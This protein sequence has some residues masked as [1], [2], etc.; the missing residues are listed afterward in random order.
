MRTN[1]MNEQ[2]GLVRYEAARHALAEARRVQDVKDIRD[3][4][5]AMAVYAKQAKDRDLIDH[6]T[7][8]RM[9]AEIRAGEMLTETK[10]RGERQQKGGDRKSKSRDAIGLVVVPA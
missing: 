3:K 4:A 10:E 5:V 1:A 7:E 9:R 8:I 6:A 2:H